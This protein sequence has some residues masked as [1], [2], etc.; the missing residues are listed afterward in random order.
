MR[1]LIAEDEALIALSTQAELEKAGHTVVGLAMTSDE[2]IKLAGL[3][4]YQFRS[5]LQS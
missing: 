2:V 5:T 1:I 4:I 3:G